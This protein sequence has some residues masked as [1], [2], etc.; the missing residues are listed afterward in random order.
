MNDSEFLEYFEE[1]KKDD[2]KKQKEAC[3]KMVKTLLS[4]S[5]N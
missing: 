1:L 5:L 3:E 2:N 4:L